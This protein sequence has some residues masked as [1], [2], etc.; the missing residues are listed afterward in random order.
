MPSG[1][2]AA[3]DL[4]DEATIRTFELTFPQSNWW[5]LLTQNYA[6]KTYIKADLKV[7]GIT[8]ADVGVRYRGNSSYNA[9]AGPKKPFKIAMDAFTPDRKLLRR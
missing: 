7:D 1:P 3:Q 9:V 5:Q 6:S 8:Y 4:Y 2:A